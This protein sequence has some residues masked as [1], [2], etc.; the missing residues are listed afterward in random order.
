VEAQQEKFGFKMF[1][2]QGEMTTLLKSCTA[3]LDQAVD[4]FMVILVQFQYVSSLNNIAAG[5]WCRSDQGHQCDERI[6]ATGPSG[7][8]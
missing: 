8:A 2:R 6:G 3:G 1:L 5:Q 7:S 4:V